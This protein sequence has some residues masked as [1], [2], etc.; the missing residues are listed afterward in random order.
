MEGL[1]VWLDFVA[2]AKMINHFIRSQVVFSPD[3]W[4]RLT[5]KLT[6]KLTDKLTNNLTNKLTN[7]LT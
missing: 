3:R 5:N 6:D 7:K 4:V 1:W 2:T